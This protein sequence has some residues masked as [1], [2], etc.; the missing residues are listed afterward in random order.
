MVPSE[1]NRL[2]RYKLQTKL[3]WRTRL[4]PD[5]IQISAWLD[6]M[7]ALLKLPVEAGDRHAIGANLCFIASQIA[8]VADFPLGDTAEPAAV[9]RA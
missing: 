8:L 2:Y 7:A 9:F 3:E 4:E 6:A 5:D 1:P